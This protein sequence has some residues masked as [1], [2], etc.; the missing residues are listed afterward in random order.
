MDKGILDLQQIV[1]AFLGA[2]VGVS[3][4]SH[5]NIGNLL[6]AIIG[7]TASSTYLTPIVADIIQ[8]TDYKYMLGLSFFLGTLGMRTVELVG[9]RLEA[10]LKATKGR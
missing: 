10:S 7:G 6:M 5:A 1:A 8:I 2:V 4:Q 9:A 3:K